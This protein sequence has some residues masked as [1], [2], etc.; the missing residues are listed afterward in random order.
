MI[1]NLSVKDI[2]SIGACVLLAV[3]VVYVYEVP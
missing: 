2:K 1:L 3:A